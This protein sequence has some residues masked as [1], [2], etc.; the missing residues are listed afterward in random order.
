[1]HHLIAVEKH[2]GDGNYSPY[3]LEIFSRLKLS[4]AR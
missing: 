3:V 1:M 2:L 4:C